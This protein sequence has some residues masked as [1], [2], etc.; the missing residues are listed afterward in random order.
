[1]VS[2]IPAK[3]STMNRIAIELAVKELRRRPLATVVDVAAVL[4]AV[5]TL[6]ILYGLK[7]GVVN[8]LAERL[9]E[10]PSHRRVVLVP[11][12][13]FTQAQVDALYAHP[14]VGWV[15]PSQASLAQQL[16]FRAA[17][18]TSW[19]RRSY[20]VMPS[21]T[22]DP[23]LPDDIDAPLGDQI[24]LSDG[25]AAEL[26]V[27]TGDMVAAMVTRNSGSERAERMFEVS[28]VV[29]LPNIMSKGAMMNYRALAHVEQWLLG[30]SVPE[31]DWSGADP[32]E[33]RYYNAVR[34]YARSLDDLDSL[35]DDLNASPGLTAKKRTREVARL[36]ALDS[37]LSAVFGVFLVL[38][39]GG[40]AIAY[41]AALCRRVMSSATT[42]RLL[43][44][45]GVEAPT[46]HLITTI[47]ALV[48][49]SSGMALGSLLSLVVARLLNDLMRDRVTSFGLDSNVCQLQGL[50]LW[51]CFAALLALSLVA[52]FVANRTGHFTENAQGS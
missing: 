28:A 34:V 51:V 7:F 41:V 19:P 10:D 6:L 37:V 23:L 5:T 8:Q 1:M 35:V 18:S 20:P 11:G 52:A 25:L 4:S 26:R 21:D 49:A 47:Q 15:V 31:L 2:S 17:S 42:W 32:S 33:E 3:G 39:V 50:H 36:F 9:L 29:D 48:I 22:G 30:Y 43:A 27:Q 44:Q 14:K 16:R 46:L 24:I 40:F 45:A 13:V 12:T 38:V